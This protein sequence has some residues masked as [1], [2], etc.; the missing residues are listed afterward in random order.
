MRTFVLLMAVC[1]SMGAGAQDLP[2]RHALIDR[3]YKAE[4]YAEVV[5]LVDLQLKE[6]VGTIWEDS[7][8]RYLYKYGRAFRKLK[9]ADAGV[10][11]A[12]QIYSLVKQRGVAKNELEALFD[13]S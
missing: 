7:T 6:A 4:R 13:L 1:A 9:D 3:A 8:H 10:G 11:A 12:E 5:R 2:R